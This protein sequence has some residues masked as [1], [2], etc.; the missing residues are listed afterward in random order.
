M[1]YPKRYLPGIEQWNQSSGSNVIPRRARPGLAGL[2]L[3]EVHQK[4]GLGFRVQGAGFTE[5]LYL[6]SAWGARVRFV[7]DA[8]GEVLLLLLLDSRYRS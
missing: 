1:M 7:H 4:L 5:Y 8:A 2:S 6:C 3:T